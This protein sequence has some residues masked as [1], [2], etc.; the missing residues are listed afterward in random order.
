[1]INNKSVTL[2]QPHGFHGP[3]LFLDSMLPSTIQKVSNAVL[4]LQPSIK[5]NLKVLS[6]FRL[7][8]L[9]EYRK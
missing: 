5:I 6:N 4:F 3:K 7:L 2:N 1:M 9:P 8:I